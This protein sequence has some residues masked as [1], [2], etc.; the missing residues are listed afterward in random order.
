MVNS[1]EI[2]IKGL[3][4]SGKSRAFKSIV[5]ALESEGFKAIPLHPLF[6]D[7][8]R[9]LIYKGDTHINL[10]TLQTNMTNA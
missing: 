3:P 8:E 10:S 2:T 7:Q 5:N 1:V 4:G 9:A 6:P